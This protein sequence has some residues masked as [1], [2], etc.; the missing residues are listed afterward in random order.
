METGKEEVIVNRKAT[1]AEIIQIVFLILLF[2]AVAALIICIVEIIKYRD[3]LQN[4]LGYNMNKFNLVSCTCTDKQGNFVNIESNL[5]KRK[6][7][8]PDQ[9]N[10]GLI[11]PN[12][13]K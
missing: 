4:P 1:R 2:V 13:T 5:T 11:I 12:V 6:I 9:L 10:P 3:M 8:Y 7:I